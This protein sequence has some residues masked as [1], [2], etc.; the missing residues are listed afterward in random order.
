MTCLIVSA[1][2]GRKIRAD[3]ALTG[4]VSLTGRVMAIGG[5]KEKSLG[6]LRDGIT[7]V[8]VPESNRPDVEELPTTIKSKMTYIYNTH[9]EGV[10]REMFVR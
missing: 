10:L 9:I 7:T 4:E 3:R 2:T 8:L 1:L 5:L 6:A